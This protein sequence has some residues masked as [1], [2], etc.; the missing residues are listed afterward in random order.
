[1]NVFRAVALFSLAVGAAAQPGPRAVV[2]AGAVFQSYA[3]ADD[4]GV[5]EVTV[6]L[7]VA[8]EV[9]NGVTVHLRTVYASV[10]GDGL[11]SLSGLGDTQLGVGWQRAVGGA[12]VD[13]S[14][15]TSVPTGQTAL[16][17]EQFSTS[18]ALAVDDYAFALPTL[19]QGAVLSPSLALAVPMGPGAAVGVGVA[20]SARASYTLFAADT[21]SY[22]PANET[23]LT[24]GIDAGLGRASSF[25]L[26]GSYVL[27]SDDSYR[28]QAFSPG[29]KVAASMQLVLGGRVVRGRLLARYRQV[30]DGAAGVT[31]R[32]VSYRRP[33]QAQLALGLG[34][35]PEDAEVALSVGARYYGSVTDVADAVTVAEEVAGVLAEQ[36]VLLDLGLAPTV[37]VTPAVRLR[38]T[39]VYTLGVAEAAGASPLT[40]YR[41]GASVQVG[42]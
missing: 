10:N 31:A 9:G 7:A 39:F 25:T 37:A 20:Y 28:G 17:D 38:G 33:S 27:Y 2:E 40:G 34:L 4:Q 36:Q 32:P 30:F 21:S 15:A 1:M 42:L 12:V 26:E 14:L 13:V 23:I 22:A 5:S 35:G 6:P 29:D 24:A 19:G 3:T 11:E 18:A 8:A 16:T 41:V